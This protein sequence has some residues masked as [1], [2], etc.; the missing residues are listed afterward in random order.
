MP[1][2]NLRTN[3]ADEGLQMPRVCNRHKRSPR[4]RNWR[5]TIGAFA[6]QPEMQAVFDAAEQERERDRNFFYGDFDY[7]P[8]QQVENRSL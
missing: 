2:N 7:I 1:D 8:A 5:Q 4:A 6:D 3:A